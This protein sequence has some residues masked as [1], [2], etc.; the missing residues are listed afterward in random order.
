LPVGN[1]ANTALLLLH[2]SPVVRKLPAYSQANAGRQQDE[3]PSVIG[4]KDTMCLVLIK[5]DHKI[6]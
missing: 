3:C 2:Y 5:V 4:K 6:K 1:P